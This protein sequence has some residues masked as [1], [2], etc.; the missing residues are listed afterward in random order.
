MDQLPYP[1][2]ARLSLP[3]KHGVGTGRISRAVKETGT[4][5]GE[6]APRVKFD[7]LAAVITSL[8]CSIEPDSD[9]TTTDMHR[10]RVPES[11]ARIFV[12]ADVDPYGY[13]GVDADDPA[14]HKVGDVWAI[15]RSP[16]WWPA[17]G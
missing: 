13:G 16:A 6:F 15:S 2:R 5:L 10:Y 11:G 9:A 7:E 1:Q 12:I 17:E 8:G 14:E 3:A 4:D